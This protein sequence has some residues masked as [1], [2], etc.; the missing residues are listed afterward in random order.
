MLVRMPSIP[1][2][3]ATPSGPWAECVTTEK[4][5][6]VTQKKENAPGFAN[7]CAFMSGFYMFL[8]GFL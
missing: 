5:K 8:L 7:F 6:A 1:V 3:G 2:R 4:R